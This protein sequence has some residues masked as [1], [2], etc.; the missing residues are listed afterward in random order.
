M[1][2]LLAQAELGLRLVGAPPVEALDR[3]APWVHSSDLLNP[4]PFLVQG[5]V[6][7]TTGTQFERPGMAPGPVAEAYVSRLVDAG[8]VALGFGTEVIRDGVPDALITA[9]QAHG[10]PLF[11]VPFQTPFIAVARANAEAVTHLAFARRSWALGAQRAISRAALQAGG[12]G[13]TVQEFSRQLQAWVGLFDAAGSLTHQS[14]PRGTRPADVEAVEDRAR[15]LLARRSRATSVMRLDGQA[16]TLQTVGRGDALRGVLAVAGDGLDHE[17]QAVMNSVV[18]MVGLASEQDAALISSRLALHGG[19]LALLAAGHLGLARSVAGAGLPHDA[20][21]LPDDAAAGS[22]PGGALPDPPIVVAAGAELEASPEA[23]AAWIASLPER[24][25]RGLFLARQDRG[26]GVDV[27]QS[28]GLDVG[29]SRGLGQREGPSQGVGQSQRVGQ[30]QSQRVGQNQGVVL[31]AQADQAEAGLAELRRRFAGRW[32]VSSPVG[33]D[34][35]PEASAQAA[36]ALDR[37]AGELTHFAEL[38]GLDLMGSVTD[39]HART[40][41]R[42][43]LQPLRE[44]DARHGTSLLPTLAAWLRL[45][46]NHEATARELGVHR[47]TIRARLR[48]AEHVG[49]YRLDGFAARAELWA[50]LR[51]AQPPS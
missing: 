10:M 2:T 29:Q 24:T 46:G 30:G 20:A 12:I 40:A 42:A 32:G 39:P 4:A 3:G 13:P 7:L 21:A 15:Q 14:L 36:A 43:M 37:G 45:D 41:A 48:T 27:G 25:S 33:Y 11:E 47:H 49:G 50:A 17:A 18:A 44:H 26:Q 23:V 16:F 9:C 38:L 22:A 35:F 51:L 5:V 31:I 19:V 6:L 1:R 8:V 28:Q 34:A